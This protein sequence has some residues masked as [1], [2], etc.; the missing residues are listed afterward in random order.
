MLLFL[1]PLCFVEIIP[2]LPLNLSQISSTDSCILLSHY[3]VPHFY[4]NFLQLEFVSLIILS[5]FSEHICLFVLFCLKV[6][7]LALS[8]VPGA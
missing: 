7:L 2:T 8:Q 5:S 6:T 3:H 4:S 1:F